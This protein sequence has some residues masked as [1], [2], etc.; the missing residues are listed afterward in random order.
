M[1]NIIL[2]LA[3]TASLGALSVT[4]DALPL[5]SSSTVSPAITVNRAIQKTEVVIV[6]KAHPM[7]RVCT[8]VHTAG[9]IVKR[10]HMM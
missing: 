6:K 7:R 3:A 2:A 10:C 8:T 5:A 9:K 1:R 4:A